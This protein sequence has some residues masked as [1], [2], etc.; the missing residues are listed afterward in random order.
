MLKGRALRAA[1]AARFKPHRIRLLLVAEAPPSEEDR[2]FYFED[3]AI[4]DSLFRYVVRLTLG[5]QPTRENKTELLGKLREAGVFLIDLCLDPGHPDTSELRGCVPDLLG[6]AVALAPDHII[7][8]KA[9][10]YTAAFVPLKR[11]GLPV[12]D[13]R[14]PFPG[15]GHQR[16]F[17]GAMSGALRTIGWPGSP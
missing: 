6:R 4:H 14:I 1:A 9:P 3:V 15:S 16:E 17:E 12:V 8:I 2:Y 13:A 7:L 11:A 5:L 10:V